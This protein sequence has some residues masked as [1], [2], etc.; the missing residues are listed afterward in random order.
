MAI[1][2]RDFLRLT[3]PTRRVIF[4]IECC[5][6]R[7]VVVVD[8]DASHK[9]SCA[10][11]LTIISSNPAV[12]NVYIHKRVRAAADQW[13]VNSYV[14]MYASPNNAQRILDT[15]YILNFPG[16]PLNA[17]SL[18][19]G[20]CRDVESDDHG[21]TNLCVY[22]GSGLPI[23]TLQ[24]L[25]HPFILNDHETWSGGS[26]RLMKPPGYYT[27]IRPKATAPPAG[28]GLSKDDR[29]DNLVERSYLA[30][31]RNGAQ[32]LALL[33]KTLETTTTVK[34]ENWRLCWYHRST[35]SPAEDNDPLLYNG[36]VACRVGA[37]IAFP[38]ISQDF[39]PRQKASCL[40]ITCK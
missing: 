34:V 1:R 13:S 18:S 26:N 29:L 8:V 38:G 32:N 6:F 11:R 27:F 19:F 33:K 2:I 25:S 4:A 10:A 16:D 3:Y 14:D 22:V 12:D 7:P 20:V 9:L 28:S 30:L 35:T 17:S 39:V 15:R 21:P 24:D 31:P 37:P 36:V 40:P 5:I 23:Y